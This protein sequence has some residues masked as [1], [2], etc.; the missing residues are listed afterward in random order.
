M[1]LTQLRSF[2]AVAQ[3]GGFTAAARLL[4]VSQ[5]TLTSQVRLLESQYGV[6]LF[7]RIGRGVTLTETGQR[8]LAVAGPLA[9][10]EADALHLLKDAGDL[11]SGTLKVGAVGPFDA[12]DMIAGFSRQ[13]PAMQVQVRFGNSEAVLRELLD[14][15]TDVA[16]LAHFA[17]DA[18]LHSVPFRRSR[19]VVFTPRDHPLAR[20]RSIRIEQL[21]GERMIVR[22]EGSTTR[23]AF[24]AA[25][26]R[27]G[28]TPRVVME[29]GSREAIREAVAKGIGIG[30]VSEPGL[31]HDE[32]LHKLT[33]SNMEVWTETHVVCLEVRRTARAVEAFLEIVRGLASPI[34]RGA[35]RTPAR[36]GSRR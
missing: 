5:P 6:E 20:R 3:A 36:T 29:L 8:L 14:F 7:H 26:S 25:L 13:Y 4:H 17:D 16:V 18:R 15:R 22:E 32:R 9:S 10:I 31:A 34:E 23:K 28:V 1:R 11:R 30:V 27:A 21:E 35:R 2:L 19:V 12:T 24:E 33:L